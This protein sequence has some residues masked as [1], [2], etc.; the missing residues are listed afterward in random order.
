MNT[1]LTIA[2]IVAII[3]LAYMLIKL[4][5]TIRKKA[6]KLFLIAEHNFLSGEGEEKLNYVVSNIYQ[7]LPS[8]IKLFISESTLKVIIQ[9]MFDEIKDLLD[10]GKINKSNE[11]E[12]K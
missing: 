8:I 3:L 12:E 4:N 5:K 2:I 11:R 1:Y 9:K 6:Y 10:D 7:Y